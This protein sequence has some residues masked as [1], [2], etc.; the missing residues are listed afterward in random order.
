MQVQ[1]LVLYATNTGEFYRTNCKMAHDNASFQEWYNRTK[2]FLRRY[3]T[4]M[5]EPNE[6]MSEEEIQA[7]TREI[8]AYYA[9]HIAEF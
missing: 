2:R 6:G 3:K 4:E 7:A 8:K 5:R 9:R 1:S